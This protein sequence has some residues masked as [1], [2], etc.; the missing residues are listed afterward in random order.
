[1]LI[2]LFFG[3]FIVQSNY[4]SIFVVHLNNLHFMKRLPL[5]VLALVVFASCN[6]EKTGYVNTGKLVE[7]YQEMI[8]AEA[9]FKLKTEK[10]NLKRDSIS[11]AFQIEEQKFQSDAKSMSQK[12]VQEAYQALAQKGQY[13]GQQLQ[14][15][16]QRLQMEGQAKIDSVITKVKDFVK[17]YGKEN[18]YTYIFGSNDAGS[19]LYGSDEKDL[20]EEILKALNEE[21]SN[22]K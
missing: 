5:L 10:F 4:F 7:G 19:V 3:Y 20:T 2:K 6:L 21:Y 11:K 14:A 12:K 16:Q 22:K 15:E 1:M 13:L 8:D 9:A 17:T 18:G